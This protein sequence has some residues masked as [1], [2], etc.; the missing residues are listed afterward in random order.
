VKVGKNVAELY[1]GSFV[2]QR[3][4]RIKLK[5]DRNME[6]FKVLK[7]SKEG[8]ESSI[9]GL[10]QIKP[11]LQ[12]QCLMANLDGQGKQDAKELGEHFETAINAM[13]TILGLIESKGDKNA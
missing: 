1:K 7:L 11:I 3:K 6:K 5:G 12:N 10:S 9:G 4:T 2:K 13:V 8:L